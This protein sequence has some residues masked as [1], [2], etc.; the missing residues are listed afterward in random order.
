MSKYY[1]LTDSIFKEINTRVPSLTFR[2]KYNAIVNEVTKC[3]IYKSEDYA[4][5]GKRL[6]QKK[7]VNKLVSHNNSGALIQDLVDWKVL[8]VLDNNSIKRKK[9]KSY[10]LHISHEQERFKF[11]PISRFNT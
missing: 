2:V 4:F 8:T 9:A 3:L 11:I 6:N 5:N 10:Q 7:H 1:I